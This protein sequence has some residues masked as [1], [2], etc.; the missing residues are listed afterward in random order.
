[1]LI[2]MESFFN[3]PYQATLAR[4]DDVGG[5]VSW[6]GRRFS[7]RF[8][9]L[10]RDNL[11]RNRLPVNLRQ[12]L[13]IT[14]FRVLSAVDGKAG[15]LNSPQE[16]SFE[17]VPGTM[18]EDQVKWQMMLD[19]LRKDERCQ[20][21]LELQD[22]LLGEAFL[23]I[24]DLTDPENADYIKAA[25][26][27]P[28]VVDYRRTI[29]T[30]QDAVCRLVKHSQEFITDL[31]S[32]RQI[33]RTMQA[34][35]SCARRSG[36]SAYLATIQSELCTAGLGDLLVRVLDKHKVEDVRLSTWR[37]IGD[38]LMGM[39][40]NGQTKVNKV[41]QKVLQEVLFEGHEDVGLWE[42]LSEIISTVGRSVKPMQAV[43]LLPVLSADEQARSEEYCLLLEQAKEAMEATRLMVEGH[44]KMMQDYL[45]SQEGN[46]RSW[47]VPGLGCWLLTRLCKNSTAANFA[48]DL[49]LETVRA[50]LALLTELAQGPNL[51]NQEF[52][53]NMGLIEMMFS[54]LAQNFKQ[55]QKAAGDM[56]P[57]TVR[58]LKAELMQMLL[59]LLE[60]RM[61]SKIHRTM[62]ERGDP[63]VVRERIMYVY[64]YFV[65]GSVAVSS[66]QVQS[67]DAA[68]VPLDGNLT[69]LML[70]TA[71]GAEL[72]EA[73]QRDSVVA[74]ELLEDLNDRQMTLLFSEGFYHVQLV[75][76]LSSHSTEFKKQVMPTSVEEEKFVD[77]PD[78]YRTQREYVRDLTAYQ[79]RHL[80]RQSFE[81]LRRFVK[82]IEVVLHGHLQS[83]HFQTPIT[84]M[85]Y[86]QGASKQRILDE[87]PFSSPDIKMKAFVHMCQ[88]LHIECQLIL[89]LSRFSLLPGRYRIWAQRNI[90]DALHRPF[91]VFLASDA[92]RM[93]DLLSL[94][95]WLSLLLA[96]HVGISLV[97]VKDS[98]YGLKWSS[99]T[100][101]RISLV[102]GGMHFACTMVW[103]FLYTCI[104]VP[105]TIRT[106]QH[107][108]PD[109]NRISTIFGAWVKY[110][111]QR[112][113]AW[114]CFLAITSATALFGGKWWV[115]SF[116]V[117]DFFCQSS[118]LQTVLSGIVAPAQ[119]L[120]MTFLGAGIV[121]FVYA[122][123]GTHYFRR[124]FNHYCDENIFVCTESILYMST[125]AGIIGL[126]SMMENVMPEDDSWYGRMTYDISYFVVFGIML[127][128][129]I[130]ALIVDSF[131]TQRR[132]AGARERVL[133][134]QSFI[135]C[136]DRKTIETVAQQAGIAD[137]FDYH[138]TYQQHKWDYMAFLFQLYEK[139]AQDYTGPEQEIRGCVDNNDVTW[140]PQGRSK[141]IEGKSDDSKEDTLI[142]IERQNKEII[143]ALGLTNEHRQTLFKSLGNLARMMR[144][145][146][147]IVKEQ[148]GHVL[149]GKHG[150]THRDNSPRPAA[151][152]AASAPEP[153][154]IQL[155]ITKSSLKEKRN[156]MSK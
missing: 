21:R 28:P 40:T 141:M 5:A 36:D 16:K 111:S 27:N 73:V 39:E 42:S 117:A 142:T 85:W 102:L 74:E 136:I 98:H 104:K 44:F 22:L 126:S 97:P 86:V 121:A 62:L 96:A 59:A 101:E 115:Y 19:A 132:E 7:A 87:I 144:D 70:P 6:I 51:R 35:V 69:H 138:E 84:A 93:Q 109:R 1:M 156:Q 47:N 56:Y 92:R 91:F 41:V 145:K 48:T 125:R 155:D 129:T 94:A 110:L 31:S 89:Q 53:G 64:L 26:A 99:P 146:T 23:R 122:A 149:E 15:F 150:D 127:L 100:A 29:V 71:N 128:N 66:G 80:Y 134:T 3:G 75:L 9:A 77:D 67:K 105:L 8:R 143:Q 38:L 82:T 140:L 45:Y 90:P 152:A 58:E 18:S 65:F 63:Q 131:Q 108:N 151:P 88:Y 95:L 119:P 106:V 43:R 114:R 68:A 14:G 37:L 123:I 49:E 57:A 81:F 116:L 147:D 124:D 76:E 33:I 2:C 135:S 50:I 130:V 54:L 46:A 72:F 34:I 24:S 78:R 4:D 17:Q 20:Q 30:V 112:A 107:A 139:D 61:D 11:F 148:L 113:V 52:L 83:I 60:G 120:L 12:Q 153:A 103:L 79:K 137:G 10:E 55:L 13:M 118:S 154:P 133:E 25:A 32:L